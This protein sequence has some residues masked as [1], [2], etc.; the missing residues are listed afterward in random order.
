MLLTSF[1]V[2][3]T[4]FHITLYNFPIQLEDAKRPEDQKQEDSGEQP[5]IKSEDNAIEMSDDLEGKLHD[6]EKG[7]GDE[8]EE[9]E[10]NE[11]EE[12]DKQMGE[13]DEQDTEKLDEQMWGSDDEEGP[14]SE[15]TIMAPMVNQYIYTR[16]TTLLFFLSF[17]A[18]LEEVQEELLY[19]PR[20]QRQH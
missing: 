6:L 1:L 10:E 4:K 13:V 18:G 2:M 11:E 16:A 15:V 9:E 12:L 19:Y 5:D 8:E 17:L 7:E 3:I 20:R 14:D